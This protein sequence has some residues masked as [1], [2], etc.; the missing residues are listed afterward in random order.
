MKCFAYLLA[1]CF[2]ILACPVVQAQQTSTYKIA[3]TFF[4]E[5][6]ERFWVVINGVRQNQQAQQNVKI[7]DLTGNAWKAKIVFENQSLPEVDKSI[8]IPNSPNQD[9]ELVYQVKRNRKGIYQVRLFSSSGFPNQMVEV[10]KGS[11]GLFRLPRVPFPDIDI[12]TNPNPTNFPNRNPVPIP[13]PNNRPKPNPNEDNFGSRGGCRLIMDERTFDSLADNVRVQSFED[14]KQNTAKQAIQHYCVSSAQARQILKLFSFEQTKLEF[15]K[16]VYDYTYD[17]QN[18][19]QVNDVFDF[20]MSVDE[21]QE[22]LKT[23][24]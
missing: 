12:N 21:L 17:T 11:G 9:A 23:K 18:F 4:S 24:R 22:Y 7:P 8:F 1:Y 5:K 10:I 20:S 6:G 2:L 3:L 16:W 19:Y 15:A 13:D 14:T